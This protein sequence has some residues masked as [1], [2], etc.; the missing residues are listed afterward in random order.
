M[1]MGMSHVA[2]GVTDLD[3]SLRFYVADLGFEEVFRLNHD[4]GSPWLIYLHA[5]GGTFIE[6]FPEDKVDQETAASYK[7]LCIRVDDMNSSLADLS[8]RGLEPLNP[9]SQGQDGN[10][11]AWFRDPDGNPIEFM[12]IMPNSPQGKFLASLAPEVL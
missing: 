12:Q 1:I 10:L 6:L 9:A 4:D 2:Y 3:A 5:G 11:Q 7:H 8:S